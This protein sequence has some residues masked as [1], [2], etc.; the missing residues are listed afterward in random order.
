[1][2]HRVTLRHNSH[3]HAEQVPY[4][5]RKVYKEN[6]IHLNHVVPFHIGMSMGH[7]AMGSLLQKG[8][9]GLR[10]NYREV[11]VAQADDERLP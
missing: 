11:L 1:M 10:K 6:K 9:G 8:H 7:V 5:T 4:P 2:I 3:F